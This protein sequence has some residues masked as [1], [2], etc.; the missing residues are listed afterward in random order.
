MSMSH[1]AYAFD[2]RGFE[3]DLRP[4]LEDALV[5]DKTGQLE[6]F[7][8]DHRDV[9]TD[10]PYEG[11]PLSDDC[12]AALENRDIHEYVDHAL[13]RFYDP[14]DDLARSSSPTIGCS[15]DRLF[16]RRRTHTRACSRLTSSR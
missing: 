5:A 3:L 2:W 7:I 1:K 10:S 12:R 4:L 13:T 14:A 11:E 15:A 8:G 6:K 16:L 9:V